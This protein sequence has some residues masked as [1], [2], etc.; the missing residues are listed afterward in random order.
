MYGTNNLNS[1]ICLQID[2]ASLVTKKAVQKKMLGER[3]R[4]FVIFIQVL[5]ISRRSV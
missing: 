5:V 1:K 2:L 3:L 4:I